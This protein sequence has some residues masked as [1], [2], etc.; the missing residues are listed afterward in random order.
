MYKNLRDKNL[1]LDLLDLNKL[2]SLK[3]L[4]QQSETFKIRDHK[5]FNKL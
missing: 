4:L 2:Q 3:L 5:E 1:R